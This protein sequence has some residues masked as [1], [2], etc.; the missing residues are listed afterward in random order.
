MAS[1]LHIVAHPRKETSTS[2]NIASEFLKQ[3]TDE[4]TELNLYA[5]HIPFIDKESLAYLEGAEN[6][7]EEQK[8]RKNT[9]EQLIE[10][11]LSADKI[12][13]TSPMWNFGPPA[14]LKAYIDQIV[15]AG[16]TFHYTEHGP[17]GLVEGKKICIIA[18][19][20]GDYSG[21]WIAYNYQETYIKAVFG[22][23]G[24]TDQTTIVYEG[25]A[26]DADKTRF[27]A[28]LEKAREEGKKF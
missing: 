25:S 3:T 16:K 4:I 2:Y 26:M 22:F 6:L 21:E 18:S 12:V 7:T 5:Q 10:Q 8:Q 9:H 27:E 28:V 17:Q 24:I 14:I 15:V 19:H 1:I 23:L 13:V 11:F 20:G